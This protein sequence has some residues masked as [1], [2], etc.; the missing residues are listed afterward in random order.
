MNKILKDLDYDKIKMN[1]NKNPIEVDT[2]LRFL[3]VKVEAS[4]NH[5]GSDNGWTRYNGPDGLIIGGGW[6]SLR[7]ED[8]TIKRVNYLDSIQYKTK[9]SNVYN[10]YVN[11]FYLFEILT[12]EGKVFFLNY[13]KD[14]I[15]KQ[16][17]S[18]KAKIEQTKVSLESQEK[19]L[20]E[21][22]S[23]LYSIGVS[24]I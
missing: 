13:Y 10:N 21:T 14:D 5:S 7:Y 18:M 19:N 6:V 16:F 9:L 24:Y 20:K 1:W 15:Q 4:T 2:L 12:D 17:D 11:P 3:T 23:E 8:G 22:V